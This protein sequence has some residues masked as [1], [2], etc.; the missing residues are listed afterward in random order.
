MDMGR[1]FESVAG[2]LTKLGVHELIAKDL[3]LEDWEVQRSLS[4]PW[5]TELS[6]DVYRK[7]SEGMELEG[8]I[9]CAVMERSRE[10]SEQGKLI[11]YLVPRMFGPSHLSILRVYPGVGS[12]IQ[13]GAETAHASHNT[14][15]RPSNSLLVSPLPGKTVTN[16]ML[17]SS[18]LHKSLTKSSAAGTVETNHYASLT[19][20][21]S[22]QE[23][24]PNYMSA[25]EEEKARYF[26]KLAST[27]ILT[28]EGIHV[29]QQS[30]GRCG[31]VVLSRSVGSHYDY[32]Q[33]DHTAAA[34]KSVYR[35]ARLWAVSAEKKHGVR[36]D[37]IAWAKSK[38]LPD[39]SE[40]D[41]PSY[42]KFPV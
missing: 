4:S 21:K 10:R 34:L 33:I 20:S 32:Y 36:R 39:L 28:C 2:D 30:G 38:T 9:Q 11:Q 42:D 6:D 27:R 23:I 41:T 18:H 14:T 17:S 7:L 22:S 13:G 5:R 40:C 31:H 26:D 15:N 16:K 29:S 24:H 1:L 25:E 8:A 12:G 35:H 3:V 19:G 37:F